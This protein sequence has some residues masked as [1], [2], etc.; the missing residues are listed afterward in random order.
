MTEIIKDREGKTRR[1]LYEILN[2]VKD[3]RVHRVE[4]LGQPY[5]YGKAVYYPVSYTTAL[6]GMVKG[7]CQDFFLQL[8]LLTVPGAPKVA[9]RADTATQSMVYRIYK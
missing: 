9:V 3:Y 4:D 7:E 5:Y 6:V 1:A 8:I 2:I